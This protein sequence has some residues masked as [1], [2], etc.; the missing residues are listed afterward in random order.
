MTASAGQGANVSP[1]SDV[2][3]VS[4]YSEGEANAFMDKQERHCL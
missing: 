3:N 1:Y 2:S 4:P